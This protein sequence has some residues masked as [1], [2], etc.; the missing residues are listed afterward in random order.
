MSTI[1]AFTTASGDPGAGTNFHEFSGRNWA[2]CKRNARSKNAIIHY[3]NTRGKLI[4]MERYRN[5]N[6]ATLTL[7]FNENYDEQYTKLYKQE[8]TLNSLTH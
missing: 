2:F 3:R 5:N 4:V 1:V 7:K 8:A 6:I